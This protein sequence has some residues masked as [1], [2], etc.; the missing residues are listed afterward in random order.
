[1]SASMMTRPTLQDL[2][3]EAMT[4]TISKVDITT[5]AVRQMVNQGENQNKEASAQSVQAGHV[6][7]D[8][9]EKLADALSYIAT[10]ME[11]KADEPSVSPGNGPGALEVT[12][13]T[14]SETNVD[15][16]QQGQATSAH[17]PPKTPAMESSGVAKDPANAMQ[18]NADMSHP[19]QPTDPIGNE[20]GKIGPSEGDKTITASALFTKNL[21]RILKIGQDEEKCPDCKHAKSECTCAKKESSIVDQIR[22]NFSAGKEKKAEDAINP[23]QISAGSSDPPAAS[24]SESAVPAQPSDVSSQASMV[25]SNQSAIDYTKGQAKA[26]PK[27]D[28][29]KVLSEPALSSATDKTLE[30]AFD[31]TGNAGVKISSVQNIAGDMHK[32]A[33]ARALL[34][35]LAQDVSG[36]KKEEPKPDAK[37]EKS[38]MLTP[39]PQGHSGF[40]AS[41]MGGGSM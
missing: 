4:G 5:E 10:E 32:V 39:T 37:K 2:V 3:K 15:A 25:G 11:K 12:Q 34:S 30:Q 41:S 20:K 18:T 24:A 9:V 14:S 40:N 21:E 38:S 17:V 7:T 31:N 8:Y 35:K 29:G 1:M 16:G 33:A 23:A 19:E 28:L 36:E 26:D 22:K 6:P 13:A 27:K